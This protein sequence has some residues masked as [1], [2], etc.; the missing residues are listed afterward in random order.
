M[1]TEKKPAEVIAE[2]Q[3]VTNMPVLH[4]ELPFVIDA[5]DIIRR[6]TFAKRL[7]IRRNMQSLFTS[8]NETLFLEP[9]GD[10]ADRWKIKLR[11]FTL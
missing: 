5:P 3:G 8:L 9:I 10:S 6:I 4:I 11:V 1:A 2:R 7:R